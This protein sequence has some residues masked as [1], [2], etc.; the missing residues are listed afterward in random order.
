LTFYLANF[1]STLLF[2]DLP[3]EVLLDAA[4]LD[5]PKPSAVMLLSEIPFDT[6]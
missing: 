5:S 2:S 3:F 4:G 1:I 6:K